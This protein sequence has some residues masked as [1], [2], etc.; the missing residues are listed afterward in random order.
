MKGSMMESHLIKL[1]AHP[2]YVCEILEEIYEINK[3][4]N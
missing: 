3:E 2:L 1:A 4:K